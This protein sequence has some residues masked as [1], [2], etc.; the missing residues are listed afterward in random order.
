M[1][2]DSIACDRYGQQEV[3]LAKNLEWH[4][5]P[6]N[7][8]VQRDFLSECLGFVWVQPS[9]CGQR[10]DPFWMIPQSTVKWHKRSTVSKQPA[11]PTEWTLG[12]ASHLSW[13][14]SGHSQALLWNTNVLQTW[15]SPWRRVHEA[16]LMSDLLFSCLWHYT[17]ITKYVITSAIN[18]HESMS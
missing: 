18:K 11:Q 12:K 17:G 8:W 14:A 6:Q 13:A 16:W 1:C 15:T 3:C 4:T 7:E 9:W 5:I 2:S 10:Q